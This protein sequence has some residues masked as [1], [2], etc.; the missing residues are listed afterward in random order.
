MMGIESSISIRVAL[1]TVAP[2][3]PLPD[4]PVLV[5]LQS[6][7]GNPRQ[8]RVG[9]G[10]AHAP[11][12]HAL[13]HHAPIQ[14]VLQATIRLKRPPTESEVIG[15]RHLFRVGRIDGQH[16]V[17]GLGAH[18]GLPPRPVPPPLAGAVTSTV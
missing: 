17:D 2:P 11:P 15:G 4:L 12:D 18:L 16:P 14:G 5:Q 6:L 9:I 7:D 13:V 8:Q 3:L 1:M 10:L